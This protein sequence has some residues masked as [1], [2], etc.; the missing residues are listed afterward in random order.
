MGFGFFGLTSSRRTR[1]HTQP[2]VLTL[3]W[4]PPGQTSGPQESFVYLGNELG[5]LYFLHSR[6]A[7]ERSCH[8]GIQPEFF[9]GHQPGPLREMP[10]C[11]ASG[12][13][14]SLRVHTLNPGATNF[15]WLEFVPASDCAV[16]R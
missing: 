11:L 15:R 13:L 2:P 4:Q 1:G 7:E 6:A 10:T 9:Q 12:T 14:F 3:T 16:P 8:A 5:P